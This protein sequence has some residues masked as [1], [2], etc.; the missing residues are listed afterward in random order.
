MLPARGF[1][2]GNGMHP[3]PPSFNCYENQYYYPTNSQLAAAKGEGIALLSSAKANGKGQC[4]N[5]G[6]GGNSH[7]SGGGGGANVAS[8]GFG[9]YEF[10]GYTL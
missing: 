1:M 7:N 9:G 2:G 10:E 3:V 8:G 4:A 6:G 5:G